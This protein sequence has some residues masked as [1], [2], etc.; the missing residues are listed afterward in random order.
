MPKTLLEKILK[1]SVSASCGTE[2]DFELEFD[3]RSLLLQK[4]VQLL[5]AE[6]V[7]R[8]VSAFEARAAQLY[9]KPTKSVVAKI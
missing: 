7:R 1:A 5:F 9:G 8:M 6:A 2:I 4:T 3:F